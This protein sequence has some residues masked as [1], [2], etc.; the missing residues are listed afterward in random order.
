VREYLARATS[1]PGASATAW[2]YFGVCLRDH[3]ERDRASAAFEKAVEMQP[4]FFEALHDLGSLRL[5][6]GAREP[7]LDALD[8]AAAARPASFEVFH[9]RGRTLQALH[10]HED[11]VADYDR[12]LALQPD[13]P[14]TWVA[15]GEAL[16]DLKR[17]DEALAAFTAALKRDPDNA[18]ALWNESLLHLT[19]GDFERGWP[20]YEYRWK[21]RNGWPRRHQDLPAWN[22]SLGTDGKTILVWWEQGFGDTLHF[23]RYVPILARSGA[24][25]VFEVQPQLKRLLSCLRESTVVDADDARPACDFQ[26]PLLSLPLAFGTRA[27]TIPADV[28]YLSP[29]PELVRHWAGACGRAGKSFASPSQRPAVPSKRTTSSVPWASATSRH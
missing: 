20:K 26:V 1:L 8:R 5:D 6:L 24:R 10:R 7:A 28:P 16:C 12:A 21:G 15:R 2:Y 4:G 9:N 19:R 29:D 17:Y 25:V 14:A 11:A 3:G 27:S 13:Q 22:A 23:S 18:D